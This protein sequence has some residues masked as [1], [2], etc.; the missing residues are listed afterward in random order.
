MAAICGF[1]PMRG[2]R[3][4]AKMHVKKPSLGACIRE[5][6]LPAER[7]RRRT[8]QRQLD[9]EPFHLPASAGVTG[10]RSYSTAVRAGEC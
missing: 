1:D 8:W 9:A 6:A 10:Q 5:A 2:W 4:H 3:C 7:R